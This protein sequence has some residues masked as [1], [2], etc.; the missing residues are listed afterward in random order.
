MIFSIRVDDVGWTTEPA[1]PPPRKRSDVGL[2]LARKFHAVMAGL[3]WLA[4]VIPSTLDKDGVAW[5]KSKPAGLVPALHG[6]D[7][8]MVDGV[9]SEFRGLDYTQCR[10]RIRAGLSKLSV[11]TEHFVPPFNA[12]EPDLEMACADEGLT[13]VWGDL[14]A[15]PDLPRATPYARYVPSWSRLY[16]ASRKRMSEIAPI[17]VHEIP[18]LL[19]VKGHAVIAL[20]ITWEASKDPEFLGVRELVGLIRSNVIHPDEYVRLGG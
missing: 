5:L 6:Y 12:L 8:R 11:A 16:G 19:G 1:D 15:T 7:H 20:H 2:S 13:V 10:Q 14:V 4:A 9:A 3:P 17:L 18:P